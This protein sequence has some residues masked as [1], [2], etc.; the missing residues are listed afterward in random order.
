MTRSRRL[1]AVLAPALLTL[2]L[3][4][5]A[6]PA[7]PPPRTFSEKV[8]VREV[9]LVLDLPDTLS[10]RRARALLPQDLVVAVDGVSHPVV[11]IEPVVAGVGRAPA[12]EPA[13]WTLLVYVDRTLSRPDTAL[14]AALALAKRAD[15]LTRLGSVTVVV[16][17][18][19]PR[20]VLD[21]AR[22][23]RR[24]AAALT[25]VASAARQER[26]RGAPAWPPA[27]AAIRRQ[28]DR[29]LVFV[30]ARR[31]TGPRALLL[32]CD[33]FDLSAK[34]LNRLSHRDESSRFT[35]EGLGRVFSDVARTLGAYGWVTVALPLRT[36]GLGREHLE[37]SDLER[38]RQMAGGSNVDNGVPPVIGAR[39][40]TAGTPLRYDGAIEVLVSP[41]TAPLLALAQATAG[42]VVGYEEQLG[43][44]LDGLAR[45]WHLWYQMPDPLDGRVRPVRASLR[46]AQQPLRTRAW[47]RSS[48]P[49]AVAAARLRLL[50]GGAPLQG[51]LPLSAIVAPRPGAADGLDLRLALP[52]AAEPGTAAPL[53]LSLV[54]AGADG[55]VREVRHEVIAGV[56]LEKGW[57][58]TVPL[59]APAG[60]TKA[61]VAVEDLGRESWGAARLDLPAP[62]PLHHPP[63]LP[64]G[65]LMPKSRHAPT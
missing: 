31:E 29:L 48:T 7:S 36:A 8:E 46:S 25:G 62:A 56:D 12:S 40:P 17:D 61:A 2:L 1:L 47:V 64:R 58:R 10:G 18:P 23:A 6:P 45:R 16:A 24:L 55:S 5:S 35:A 57:R 20:V 65:R 13:P 27:D 37:P 30:G 43:P 44:A 34:E 15:E 53:R 26:D 49:E 3:A 4:G 51:T 32:G 14:L 33:S 9:E 38:I 28:S 60:A 22:D 63:S 54:F 50:L 52:A 21:G 19:E 41:Q 39:P 59:A 42:T 11:R